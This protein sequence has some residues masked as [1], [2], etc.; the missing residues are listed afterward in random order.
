MCT[1]ILAN[2]SSGDL[3]SYP[4]TCLLLQS[5]SS[6]PP[7][8]SI[9]SQKPPCS[10]SGELGPGG[11][12]AVQAPAPPPPGLAVFGNLTPSRSFVAMSWRQEGSFPGCCGEWTRGYHRALCPEPGLEGLTSCDCGRFRFYGDDITS[13]FLHV[14]EFWW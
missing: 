11:S 3:G 14:E 4:S 9:S 8:L 10:C 1:E 2:V 5:P 12:L 7:L 6:P 13:L